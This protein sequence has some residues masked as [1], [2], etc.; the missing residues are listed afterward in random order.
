[1]G[2]RAGL[3]RGTRGS[4]SHALSRQSL[5]DETKAALS[6][7][8]PN[9][10]LAHYYQY[11]N[12]LA[13][14]RFLL[15]SGARARLLH[16]CFMGDADFTDAARSWR[17]GWH[18]QAASPVSDGCTSGSGVRSCRRLEE[19]LHEVFLPVL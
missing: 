2:S 1:L 17:N 18:G 16:I 10:W 5:L 11:V 9:D 8:N 19:R 12:R 4:P 3:A 6:P 13:T 15:D 7:G 14:L